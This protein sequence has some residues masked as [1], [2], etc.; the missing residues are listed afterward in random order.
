M[1]LIKHSVVLLGPDMRL[2]ILSVSR[3]F[4]IK[5]SQVDPALDERKCVCVWFY[6]DGAIGESEG[7]VI[8]SEF[9]RRG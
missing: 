5:G 1:I 3:H 9:F 7:C 6:W 8:E 4:C 2:R